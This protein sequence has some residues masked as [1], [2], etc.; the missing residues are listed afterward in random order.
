MTIRGFRQGSM[1]HLAAVVT[2]ALLAAGTPAAWAGPAASAKPATA[3]E[4]Q[5]EPAGAA[6]Y[7]DGQLKGAT[8]VAVE[9]ILS[10]DHTVRVVKDGFLENSR[11]GLGARQRPVAARGAD[12]DAE[13]PRA[14]RWCRSSPASPRRA[15]AGAAARSG[16]SSALGVAAARGWRPSCAYRLLTSNDPPTVSGVTASP[17]IALQGATSVS[18]SASATDPDN[19]SLTYSWNFG[20]GGTGTGAS[21]SHVY[22]SRGTLQRH[23]RGLGRQERRRRARR[24]SR[25]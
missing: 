20:D 4:V 5:S 6:V 25:S 21:P 10:G 24:T 15:A 19:D 12:A 23:R 9:G 2:A 3:L 18:F 7:V 16:S 17:S 22:T 8:P 13:P 1:A 11:V 14:R